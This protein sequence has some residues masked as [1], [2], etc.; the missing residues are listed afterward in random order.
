MEKLVGLNEHIAALSTMHGWEKGS[1]ALFLSHYRKS[2]SGVSE[3][4]AISSSVGLQP[5]V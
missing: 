2:E 3:D 5:F 1:K 4:F